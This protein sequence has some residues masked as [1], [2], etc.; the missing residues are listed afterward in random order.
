M[1]GF[2]SVVAVIY[3]TISAG[4]AAIASSKRLGEPI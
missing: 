3:F 1:K 2:I 4:Q